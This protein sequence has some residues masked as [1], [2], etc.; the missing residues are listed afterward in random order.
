MTIE[1]QLRNVLSAVLKVE[2]DSIGDLSSMHTIASWDS[3]QHMILMVA[4]EEEFGITIPEDV[5]AQATSFIALK[6]VVEN[7]VGAELTR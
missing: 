5:A 3:L 1:Q 4:L 6:G 7:L 2:P